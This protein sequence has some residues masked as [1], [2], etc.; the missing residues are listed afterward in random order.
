[1]TA[2]IR[3]A[4]PRNGAIKS[5][6]QLRIYQQKT[7]TRIISAYT[8]SPINKHGDSNCIKA[9]R[10]LSATPIDVD[11]STKCNAWSRALR[12]AHNTNRPPTY[13]S[14]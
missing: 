7:T 11:T 5:I 8:T 6:G 13:Y 10:C 1:M 2:N 9:T 12:N 3:H 14:I 4:S